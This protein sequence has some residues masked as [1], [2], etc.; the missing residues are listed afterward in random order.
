MFKFRKKIIIIGMLFLALGLT[1][2]DNCKASIKVVSKTKMLANQLYNLKMINMTGPIL[3]LGYNESRENTKI[4][5]QLKVDNKWI[6]VNSTSSTNNN[7][8]TYNTLSSGISYKFRIASTDGKSTIYSN[9]ISITTP[10][11]INYKTS[12]FNYTGEFKEGLFDGNGLLIVQPNVLFVKNNFYEASEYT[13]TLCPKDNLDFDVTDYSKGHNYM[14]NL[15]DYF[16]SAKFQ[17]VFKNGEIT[18]GT[19]EIEDGL[20]YEGYFKNF[21][22]NGEGVI[23]KTKNE[24]LL[25]GI[26]END[27]YIVSSKNDINDIINFYIAQDLYKTA[28]KDFFVTLKGDDKDIYDGNYYQKLESSFTKFTDDENSYDTYYFL[29]TT[30]YTKEDNTKAGFISIYAVKRKPDVKLIKAREAAKSIIAKIIKPSMTE[31]QKELAI[32]DYIVNNTKYDDENVKKN[33]I[34]KDEHNAYGPL[35]NGIGVCDGYANAAKL[36]FDAAG[37]ESI[38]V[39]GKADN[40]TDGGSVGHAWNIVKIDGKYYQIDTTWDDPVGSKDVLSYEY[41]NVTDDKISKNHTWDK[42]S[43]PACTDDK[44]LS[45]SN[46]LDS[47]EYGERLGD[48]IY[49]LEKENNFYRINFN[50]PQKELIAQD[51]FNYMVYGDSIYIVAG[52]NNGTRYL[53]KMSNDSNDRISIISDMDY[54]FKISNDIIYYCSYNNGLYSICTVNLDGSGKTMLIANSRCFV[55]NGDVLYFNNGLDTYLY[56]YDLKMGTSYLVYNHGCWPVKIVGN[57]LSCSDSNKNIFEIDLP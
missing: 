54:I 20:I 56:K 44:F 12:K 6:K 10:K 2:L 26:W 57:K 5:L 46:I 32:H 30:I 29:R 36:L 23:Y 55:V 42:S 38:V 11:T 34:S 27:G 9:E 35:I 24:P 19:L 40:G 37:I 33:A 14:E 25:K 8:I 16:Y 13:N 43:V 52:S 51:V 1:G 53:Y 7:K 4:E 50:N 21:R 45:L 22:K 31:L 48:C 28:D 39:T 18:Y 41:F 49:Y 47:G 3:N 15:F 17:G